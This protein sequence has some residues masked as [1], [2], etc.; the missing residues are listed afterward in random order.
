MSIDRLRIHWFSGTGN[1]LWAVHRLE[2]HL[3]PHGIA[4]E[5]EPLP[6]PPPKALPETTA[7][8][9]AFPVYA[10]GPPPF[11]LRWL[12]DLPATSHPIPAIVL[13][14]MAGMSGLVK[15]PVAAILRAKGYRPWAVCELRMPPNYIHQLG[16]PRREAAIRTAADTTV[17]NFADALAKGTATWPWRPPMPGGLACAQAVFRPLARWLGHSFRADPARCTRCG[18]CARLCPV[19]N[20]QLV[21]PGPPTFANQC[22]QCLRCLVHCPDSAIVPRRLPFLFRPAY[23][24]PEAEITAEPLPRPQESAAMPK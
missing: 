22:E 18:L 2:V 20:I 6:G 1:T 10:Q 4:V 13:S 12:R 23:R 16:D 8:G 3:A 24:C 9:V 21:P 11:I 15:R 19:G 14:T 7:L 17:A 5:R